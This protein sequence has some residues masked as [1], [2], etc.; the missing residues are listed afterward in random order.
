MF[1]VLNRM[2]ELNTRLTLAQYPEGDPDD[3]SDFDE[4]P[5]RKLPPRNLITFGWR[6]QKRHP[7][8]IIFHHQPPPTE[9]QA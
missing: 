9:A 1:E 6:Y 8:L 3:H 2:K 4:D 5:P 7:N